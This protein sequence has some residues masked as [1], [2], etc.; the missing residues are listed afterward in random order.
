VRGRRSGRAVTLPVQYA[1]GDDALWVW[2]GHPQTK[3]WWRNLDVAAPV[4]LRLLGQDLDATA[5][6]LHGG[7]DP[8]EVQ[9]GLRAWAGRFPRSAARAGFGGP[10]AVGDNPGNEAVKG[11]VIVRISPPQAALRQ[12][13]AAT[14]VPG[15]G[16]AAAVRRQPLGAYFLLTFTCSWGYWIPVAAA[17]GRPSHFPGLL[18]PMLAAIVVTAIVRGRPGLRDLGSRMARWRVP[19]R[20]YA[21]ALA[22]LAAGVVALGGLWLVGG[23]LPS[24]DQLSTM[25]GLPTLGW[26]A[27]LALTL[28]VNGYGEETGWRGFAWPRLRQRH[29]LAGAALLLTVPWA[30]WHLP[31]FWLDTG[32]RGFPL[33]LLPGFFVGMAAGAVVLGWLYERAR[34]SILIVALFHA[35]LNMASATRGTEGVVATMVS[36]LVIAWAVAILRAHSRRANPGSQG[37]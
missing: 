16:L 10:P 5:Q 4:R 19:L 32:M 2:P 34:C 35:C 26:V 31:T 23:N 29:T 18:G 30:L 3:T 21:A 12:A 9:R 11:A 37:P 15:R 20:W 13:R 8:A 7:Q 6:A 27:V 14:Q 24:L 33:L 1:A 17:G 28:V 36:I 22:P 25:P